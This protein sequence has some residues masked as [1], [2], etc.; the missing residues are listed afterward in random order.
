MEQ[1]NT[2]C[3]L[4]STE[5][6]RQFYLSNGYVEDGLPAGKFGTSSGYPMAKWLVPS[7]L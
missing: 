5:T 2:R 7:V 3:I 4:K 1:G 6:A